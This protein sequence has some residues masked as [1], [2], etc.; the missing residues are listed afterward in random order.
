MKYI[1]TYLAGI[2]VEHLQVLLLPPHWQSCQEATSTVGA[3][4]QALPLLPCQEH[5]AIMSLLLQNQALFFFISF[6]NFKFGNTLM[7][8]EPFLRVLESLELRWATIC[9]FGLFLLP[10]HH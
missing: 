2:P 9:G 10:P 8:L 6:L 4:L 3:P 1:D 5:S 7:A